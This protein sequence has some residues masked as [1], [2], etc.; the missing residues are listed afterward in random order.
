MELFCIRE[1]SLNRLFSFAVQL[2]PRSAQPVVPYPLLAVFPDVLGHHFT[3]V[4]GLR[5]LVPEW[6]LLALSRIR[7]ILPVSL[8]VGRYVL[9]FLSSW[10]NMYIALG[11]VFKLP[12]G[13]GMISSV[14]N[15][16]KNLSSLLT[17]ANGRS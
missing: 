11:I 9:Q 1:A 2:L 12:F 6:T 10:V 13:Y 4:F 3:V 14:G 7:G 17:T 8:A 15:H 5:A 16:G